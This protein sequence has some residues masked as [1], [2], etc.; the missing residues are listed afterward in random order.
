VNTSIKFRNLWSLF[1][2]VLLFLSSPGWTQTG[3]AGLVNFHILKR[4]LVEMIFMKLWSAQQNIMIFFREKYHDFWRSFDWVSTF[5]FWSLQAKNYKT[6]CFDMAILNF[7][8]I[9]HLWSLPLP[10]SLVYRVCRSA[11]TTSTWL[12]LLET[13]EVRGKRK[14][15]GSCSQAPLVT[16]SGSSRIK[17]PKYLWV[18]HKLRSVFF[19]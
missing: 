12:A 10:S 6:T 4:Y 18:W 13:R 5:F 3:R 16:C 19:F 9:I 14:N 7:L 1:D 11:M 8:F 15:L 2:Q 17:I